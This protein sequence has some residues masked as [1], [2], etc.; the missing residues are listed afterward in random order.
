MINRNYLGC[1][2]I[3]RIFTNLD[4]YTKILH[5]FQVKNSSKSVLISVIR[6]DLS[7]YDKSNVK[8]NIGC[9]LWFILYDEKSLTQ[10][11]FGLIET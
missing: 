2:R 6:G 4:T 3:T 7:S 8:L 5:E 1:P 11:C 10:P 9:C